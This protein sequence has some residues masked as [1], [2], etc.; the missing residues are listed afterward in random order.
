MSASDRALLL[1]LAAEAREARTRLDALGVRAGDWVA[2]VPAEARAEAMRDVQ[3]FDTLGQRFDVLSALLDGLAR[4]KTADELL[5]AVPL[6]DMAA[7]LA[8]AEGA[9]GVAAGDLA[10][11]D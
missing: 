10:L 6:A 8:G 9:P 7:R 2:S 11:F 5:A 3:A 1:A 4:G